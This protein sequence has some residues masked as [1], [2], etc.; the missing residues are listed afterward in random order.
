MWIMGGSVRVLH[1]LLFITQ[2][3]R[4]SSP[5]LL[6]ATTMISPLLAGRGLLPLSSIL[7]IVG[8]LDIGQSFSRPLRASGTRGRAVV[9][10][11]CLRRAGSSH[12]DLLLTNLRALTVKS[13]EWE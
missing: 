8:R 6:P 5:L 10:A 3:E 7:R 9:M 2:S 11:C 12:P 13:W 4:L 1:A